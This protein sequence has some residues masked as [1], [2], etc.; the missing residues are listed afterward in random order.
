MGVCSE[1]ILD[2]AVEAGKLLRIV[3]PASYWQKLRNNEPIPYCHE[4]WNRQCKEN[5]R[6]MYTTGLAKEFKQSGKEVLDIGMLKSV[7]KAEFRKFGLMPPRELEKKISNFSEVLEVL[8]ERQQFSSLKAIDIDKF[9]E[10][11]KQ[12]MKRLEHLAQL[13]EDC[14]LV[15]NAEK[16]VF[17]LKE[18]TKPKKLLQKLVA[19]YYEI[20][21]PIYSELCEANGEAKYNNPKVLQKAIAEVLNDKFM[22][23]ELRENIDLIQR[24]IKNHLTEH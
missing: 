9:Q 6:V 23:L 12:F 3:T 18:T 16:Q 2:A 13:F 21:H 7:Y 20:L 15:V 1:D 19:H 8:L 4:E 5:S 11:Y 24:E 14:G 17:E 22:D 10:E